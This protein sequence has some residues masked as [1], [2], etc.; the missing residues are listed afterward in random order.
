MPIVVNNTLNQIRSMAMGG[1][2]RTEK[3]R[4]L[5]ELVS[6][7][8]GYRWVGIFDIGP[9][10]ATILGWSGLESPAHR[11][12]SMNE[13]LTSVAIQERRAVICND[14]R[15]EGRSLTM[16]PETLSEIIVPVISPGGGQVI[17]TIGVE[18]DRTDAFSSRDQEVIEQCAQ[19]ALPLWLLR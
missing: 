7:L 13:G 18:S 16:L 6:N 3:A 9:E 1:D 5:A 17:G 10:K 14:V 19:S 12:F 11:S 15:A 8:G 4:R 2:D